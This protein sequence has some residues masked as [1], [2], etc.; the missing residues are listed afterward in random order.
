MFLVV[1]LTV[2]LQGCQKPPDKVRAVK[3]EKAPAFSLQDLDGEQVSLA[4]FAGKVVIVEFWATWCP[5]C[6]ESVPATNKLY[7]KYRDM[8]L[9]AVAVAVQDQPDAVGDYIREWSIEMPVLMDDG[10]VSQ[11]YGVRGIPAMFFI[12][13]AGLVTNELEGYRPSV[14]REIESRV[15][16]MLAEPVVP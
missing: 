7:R 11:V 2:F 13:R 14:D 9:V 16:E 5:P 1:L 8:G 15:K 3:G 12:N 4:D 10:A 6:R